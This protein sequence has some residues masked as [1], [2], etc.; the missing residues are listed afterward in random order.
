M[1]NHKLIYSKQK[2]VHSIK[3]QS[4]VAPNGLTG[5]PV[6]PFKS[7]CWNTGS[8]TIITATTDKRFPPI[9]IH[10]TSMDILYTQN[11]VTGP[12]RENH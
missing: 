3:F 11:K 2:I 10:C 6:D 4:I 7:R 8:V 5:N 1:Q 12:F 9:T